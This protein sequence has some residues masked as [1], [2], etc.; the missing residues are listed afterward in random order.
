M[1][2]DDIDKINL[3]TTI[4]ELNNVDI[5]DFL[6]KYEKKI[7]ELNEPEKKIIYC[8]KLFKFTIIYSKLEY[9][10]HLVLKYQFNELKSLHLNYI[11]KNPNYDVFEYYCSQVKNFVPNDII[12]ACIL[13]NIELN[14]FKILLDKINCTSSEYLLLL[15]VISSYNNLENFKLVYNKYKDIIDIT[16]TIIAR[17]QPLCMNM[18]YRDYTIGYEC[19]LL[20]YSSDFNS[21]DIVGYLLE[22]GVFSFQSIKCAYN[23]V[24]ENPQLIRFRIN[25]YID[26][27]DKTLSILEKYIEKY[28]E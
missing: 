13:Y 24:K 6:L 11:L 28:I 27:K 18:D 25:K 5:D 12:E 14:K 19:D 7:D 15:K 20:L 10:H 1:L 26:N 16:K 21:Y 22:L 2:N 4:D 9:I 8:K 23:Y 17:E 3:F